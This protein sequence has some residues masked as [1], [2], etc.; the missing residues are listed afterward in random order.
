MPSKLNELRKL[1]SSSKLIPD[2]M[3]LEDDV[4]QL[5]DD[6]GQLLKATESFHPTEVFRGTFKDLEVA[7]KISRLYVPPKDEE[8]LSV[9]IQS[10]LNLYP[11][12]MIQ[13]SD[14]RGV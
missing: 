7:V 5:E 6:D 10:S 13:P 11:Q 1:C 4:G 14:T 8:I 9:S 3:K 2:S 12:G